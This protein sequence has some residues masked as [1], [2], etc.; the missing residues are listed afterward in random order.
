MD[1]CKAVRVRI[2]NDYAIEVSFFQDEVVIVGVK[3]MN[4][5]KDVFYCCRDLVRKVRQCKTAAEERD[6]IAKESAALRQ[7]FKEQ[8]STYRHRYVSCQRWIEHIIHGIKLVIN[9]TDH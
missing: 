9:H 8:D 4:L 5:T 6:V 7:A 3:Y 1:W 2:E